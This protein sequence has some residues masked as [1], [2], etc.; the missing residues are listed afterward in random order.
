MAVAVFDSLVLGTGN[1]LLLHGTSRTR[2]GDENPRRLEYAFPGLSGSGSH[3][4]GLGPQDIE[5]ELLA[6]ANTIAGLVGFEGNIRGKR[7]AGPKQFTTESGRVLS[8][9]EFVKLTQVGNEE[10]TRTDFGGAAVTAW[11]AEYRLLL[12]NMQP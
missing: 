12:R 5:V 7:G 8:Y 11:L 9:V 2:L 3:E 1:V 6:V 4:F 10:R